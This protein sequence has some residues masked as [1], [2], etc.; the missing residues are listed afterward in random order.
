MRIAFNTVGRFRKGYNPNEVDAFFMHAREAYEGH[1][2]SF[3]EKDVQNA[4]FTLSKNGYLTS[5]VDAA[6]DRLALAT[7]TNKKEKFIALRGYMA[8]DHYIWSEINLLKSRND[9]PALEKFKPAQKNEIGYDKRQVDLFVDKVLTTILKKASSDQITITRKQ[10]KNNVSVSD[11]AQKTFSLKKG[12]K[13]Y[14]ESSVDAY[15]SKAS[16]ILHL[17]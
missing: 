5:Q 3:T 9:R 8:W 4:V 14:D 17:A 7:A 6:L 16:I 13:G 11:I 1:D 15:L 12:S 2:D 10:L